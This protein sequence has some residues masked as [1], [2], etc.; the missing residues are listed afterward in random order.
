MTGNLK[1]ADAS[2]C[3]TIITPR[4]LLLVSLARF[5]IVR[6][7]VFACLLPLVAMNAGA[8]EVRGQNGTAQQ[9]SLYEQR[10]AYLAALDDLTAGRTSEFKQAQA[11]LADYAL[12]PYLAYHELQSSLSRASADDIRNFQQEYDYLP[13]A[14]IVRYRWLKRLGS[15]R[16]WITLL[17]NYSGSSNTELTCYRL[18]ALYA[19]GDPEAAFTEVPQLWLVPR[20]QPKACDPLFDVWIDAGN[21]TEA[22]VWQRLQLALEA[23]ARTLARY[24]LRFFESSAGTAAQAYYNIHITPANIVRT[25][26]YPTDNPLYRDVIRHGLL[27]LARTDP[28]AAGDAW[29]IYQRS[30]AFSEQAIED[31]EVALAIG[32]ADQGRFPADP[33]LVPDAAAA[34]IAQAAITREDWPHAA[35]WVD[36]IGGEER[37]ERRWQYWLA[38]S[39]AASVF[40][41]QR[42]QKTY[43]AL[44]EYRDYYGFL[45]AEQIGR[46]MRLNHD[47]LQLTPI[48]I[49][50]LRRNPAVERALELYAVG[51]LVN[52]RREWRE[53][54][55]DLNDEDQAAAA[56]LASSIGWTSQSIRTASTEPL[57]DT[58]ELRFPMAYPDSFEQVAHATNVS[59][60]FLQAIARQES[61]FDPRARSSANARGLMQLMHPTAIGIARRLG[62]TP[63]TVSEL[64]DPSVNVELAGHHLAA[65]LNRYS[66]QRPLAAAAYNAGESRVTRWTRDRSGQ[67]MDVWIETIPFRETRNYVKNVLAFDQVYSQ[68]MN[69]PIPMLKVHEAAIL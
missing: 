7:A 23:N 2:D 38:R 39:L 29:Q 14:E 4:E 26:R 66:Q 30:G 65:L 10:M 13:V 41:S 43:E 22:M 36:R 32:N 48:R 20:S 5:L 62:V 35:Y 27:R 49:N 15:R 57:R 60:S 24:L 56:A 44:A 3:V 64:Y 52:A 28:Q 17:A 9:M 37:Q 16:D 40:S 59:R 34:G 46:P 11:A 31:I 12:A 53:L 25:H 6:I 54:L 33:A 45:A 61:A 50:Q 21:L 47:P 42:A 63:P 69:N 55:P 58:L 51:D 18:R 68:L 67:A 19:T 1:T 8:Q